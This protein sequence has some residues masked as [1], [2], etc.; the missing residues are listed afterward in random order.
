MKKLKE[1]GFLRLELLGSNFKNRKVYILVIT[2]AIIMATTIQIKES[3]KQMLERI[4]KIEDITTYD[5]VITELAKDKLAI[6]SSIFGK[7]KGIISKFKKEDKLKL[8][9]F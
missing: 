7:G 8:H 6:P 1:T 5:D 4:K 2:I 3:T 9:E